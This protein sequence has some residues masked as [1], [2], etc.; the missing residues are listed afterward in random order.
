[1]KN[2]NYY[3]N[4]LNRENAAGI[5][6]FNTI[7]DTESYEPKIKNFKLPNRMFKF[8][9]SVA[10]LLVTSLLVSIPF[11]T[12]NNIFEK[13]KEIE[14]KIDEDANYDYFNIKGINYIEL[15]DEELG[16]IGILKNNDTLLFKIEMYFT[17]NS[18]Y[19]E[20]G[21]Y[22]RGKL[23]ESAINSSHKYWSKKGYDVKSDFLVKATFKISYNYFNHYNHK[24]ADWDHNQFNLYQPVMVHSTDTPGSNN[25]KSSTSTFVNYYSPLASGFE[26]AIDT[27]SDNL[28][29]YTKPKMVN[30]VPSLKRL[31][32][33]RIILTK[34]INN[35]IHKTEVIL[36]YIPTYEL[37]NNLPDR[38]KYKLINELNLIKKI[39][40]NEITYEEAC[41]QLNDETNVLLDCESYH[42]DLIIQSIYPSPGIDDI[43]LNFMNKK[44]Q[45]LTIIIYDLNGIEKQ[46]VCIN[47]LF[48]AGNQNLSLSIN[49]LEK[50][51]YIIAIIDSQGNSITSKFIKE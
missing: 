35:V 32:P 18:D 34:N 5:N 43:S 16:K 4:L 2:L 29:S 38:Y 3:L 19:W 39:E 23:P 25:A 1:M 49:N 11:V 22:K 37:V 13:E 42:H 24:Y 41:S 48:G 27:L 40:K 50:G 17:T 47:K 33:I 31:I 51:M 6:D 10:S 44:E 15:T 9:I 7:N 12:L 30:E 46:K 28:F 26:D 36:W 20:N 14:N 45:E 21:G 8:S